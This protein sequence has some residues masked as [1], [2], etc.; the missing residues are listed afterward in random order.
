LAALGGSMVGGDPCSRCDSSCGWRRRLR[1]RQGREVWCWR[2]Q[3][4]PKAA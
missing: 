3:T 2:I 1:H 4:P